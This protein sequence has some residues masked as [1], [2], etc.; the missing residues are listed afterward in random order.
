MNLKR[1]I[2]AAALALCLC[3]G[4]VGAL[5]AGLEKPE[6]YLGA[7]QGGESYGGA[8][9]YYLYINDYQD[10][11]FNID[12]DIYRIWSFGNMSALL[13]KERPMAAFSANPEEGFSL[14]GAMDFTD[15][16]IELFVLECNSPDLPTG[17]VI[18]FQRAD[19]DEASPEG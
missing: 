1:K 10:G 18:Q 9:E 7:W 2:I 4:A 8:W 3:L 12:L 17:T 19:F 5:A 15:D 16:G 13:S 6:S 11:A 14:M